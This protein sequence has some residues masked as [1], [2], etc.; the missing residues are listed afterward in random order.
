MRFDPQSNFVPDDPE[1]ASP[2][3]T[4]S[5]P[6]SKPDSKPGD[7]ERS[8]VMGAVLGGA[9]ALACAAAAVVAYVRTMPQPETALLETHHGQAPV[10]VSS[11]ST[12]DEPDVDQD[13]IDSAPGVEPEDEPSDDSEPGATI[14]WNI[15]ENESEMDAETAEVRRALSRAQLEAARI[16]LAAGRHREAIPHLESSIELDPTNSDA[17]Y[18]LGLSYIRVGKLGLAREEQE[19]LR[20]LDPSLANLLGNLIRNTSATEG[21]RARAF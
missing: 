18:R 12:A 5:K 7:A 4:S 10:I 13:S 19:S 8:G 14:P 15:D 20:R 11:G 6:S 17:H 16:F 1:D 3:E 9:I 21:R 2:D